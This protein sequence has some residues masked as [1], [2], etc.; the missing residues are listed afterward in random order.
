MNLKVPCTLC[1][2][3]FCRVPLLTGQKFRL[4]MAHGREAGGSL[5]HKVVRRYRVCLAAGFNAVM[6][7]I[8]EV[9]LCRFA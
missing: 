8:H 5:W 7:A 4:T 3:G 2:F 9:G 1:G 6:H